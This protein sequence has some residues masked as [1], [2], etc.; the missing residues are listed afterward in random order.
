MSVEPPAPDEARPSTSDAL[1]RALG[2]AARRAGLDPSAQTS[3]RHVAWAA[4]GGWR[5]IIESVLPSL[6]FVVLFTVT[7]D[8]GT[9]RGDL[10]LSLGASVGLAAVFSV[11][12]LVQRSPASAALGGLVATAAAAALA[13]LTGRGQDNFILGFVTNGAYG[14]ALLVSALVGWPLIGLA[15][16]WLMGD[17]TGWRRDRRKRRAFVW[18]T[19]AW[20]TLFAVRLAV[21]LPF[22][23]AGDVP[24]LGTLKIAMGLPLFAPLVVVT[25][26]VA[27][28]LYPPARRA[29]A[30]DAESGQE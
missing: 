7:L 11:V 12:R 6:V 5:G 9:G 2:S 1:A 20:A 22:Y 15:V 25:W 26:L 27:R 13:L 14:L 17:A 29:A 28:A 19:L 18:I 8:S 24:A 10:L 30:S 21:Q 23:F 3:A 4:M 16:G